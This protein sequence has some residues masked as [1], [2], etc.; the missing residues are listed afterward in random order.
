MLE[1]VYRFSVEKG[2]QNEFIDWLRANEEDL[3][4]HARPGWTYIGTWLTV[5]G[6]GDYD[7]ESRWS[8]ESYASLGEGWGD[9]T[10][11]RLLSEFFELIDSVHHESNLLRNV[12][13]VS[14]P[15]NV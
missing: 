15:P 9:E 14:S 1:Y 6:F 10:A 12:A 8:L 5:G 7:G 4:S 2:R 13:T 3:K 11:Q